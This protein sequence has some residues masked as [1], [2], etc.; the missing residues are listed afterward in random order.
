VRETE[1]YQ[2]IKLYFQN[3]GF[4]VNAEVKSCDIVL[5]KDDLVIVVELKVNM[6]VVLLAQACNRQKKADYVYVA[7]PRPLR[8]SL[9]GKW[10][11]II[12]MLKRLNIG[13]IF[14]DLR[15]SKNRVD[16]I[17]EPKSMDKS[18]P[19]YR[20]KKGRQQI[21]NET[22]SRTLDLNLGGSTKESI[23]TGYREKAL[24]IAYCLERFGELST[25]QLKNL[26]ADGKKTYSILYSNYYNWFRKVEKGI[27]DLED[28]AKEG[29]HK[30]P[31]LI[32]LFEEKVNNIL[33]QENEQ[34]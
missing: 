34:T 19:I 10:R 21:I 2:P 7:I 24:Y 12:S 1:L 9:R 8:F 4:Q 28:N 5:T 15:N 17:Y 25:K 6:S 30:Y 32:V 23:L 33:R 11:D 18:S 29:I 27:Y 31:E 16:V 26:G 20:Q 22:N 14:V 3:L 13:L